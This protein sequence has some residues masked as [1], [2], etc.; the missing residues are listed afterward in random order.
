MFVFQP[1]ANDYDTLILALVFDC[2]LINVFVSRRISDNTDIGAYMITNTNTKTDTN[3][4]VKV[5]VSPNVYF[6]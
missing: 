1:I 4:I 6:L 5:L 3:T 2:F